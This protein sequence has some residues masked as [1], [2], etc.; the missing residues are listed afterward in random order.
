MTIP[1]RVEAARNG[2]NPTVVCRMPSGWLVMFDKQ[3]LPGRLVL[4]CDPVVSSLNDLS[5][6]QSDAFL[7]DM[8][9]AGDALL[10]VTDTVR[11]N[12]AILCNLDPY[13]HGHI[14]PRYAWEP[15]EMRTKPTSLYDKSDW[16]DFDPEVDG[17]LMRKIAEAIERRA[18]G[19]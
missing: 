14:I 16:R 11:I 2:E 13:L 5:V 17:E 7:R 6:E 9:I 3:F 18:S 19:A 8:R 10:E 1:E 12:Y 15:E 4:L